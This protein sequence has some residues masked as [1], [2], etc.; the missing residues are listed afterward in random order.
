MS[1]KQSLPSNGSPAALRD[2]IKYLE[3]A[4]S[5]RSIRQDYVRSYPDSNELLLECVKVCIK[6]NIDFELLCK[7]FDEVVFHK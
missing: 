1:Y 3:F 2:T 5:L 6:I 4:L 7:V